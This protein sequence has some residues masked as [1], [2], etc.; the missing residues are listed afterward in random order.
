LKNDRQDC[1]DAGMNDYLTK[2][3]KQGELVE[4]LETYS[5]KAIDIRRTA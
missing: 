3:V 5:G 2:P 1:L 4:K